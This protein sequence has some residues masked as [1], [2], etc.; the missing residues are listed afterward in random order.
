MRPVIFLDRDGVIDRK[1]ADGAYVRSWAE[2]AFLPGA[3]EALV[4]LSMPDGP[5]LVVVTNQR[6]IAR[7]SLAQAD[8]E[9][10]HARMR[11]ALQAAGA[12]LDAIHVCPHEI[13]SCACR[14]PGIGLFLDALRDDPS[15]DRSRAAMVGDSLSDL[16]AAARL[17]IP[18]FLVSPDPQPVL[19]DAQRAGI[20]V[21]AHAPSL[22]ALV[23]L[24]AFARFTAVVAR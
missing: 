18:G 2:F 1:P 21:A 4:R 23:E 10:I 17:E 14:K 7:G 5:A 9:D 8:L 16:E 11:T 22:L 19:T 12:K 6:G 13:D 15:L 20:P 24:G 3:V